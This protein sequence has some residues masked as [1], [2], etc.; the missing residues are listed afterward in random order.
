MH[1]LSYQIDGLGDPSHAARLSRRLADEHGLRSRAD[2]AGQW[3]DV[4]VPDGGDVQAPDQAARA[5]ATYYGLVLTG[6]GER[7]A[8]RAVLELR[9]RRLF[10]GATGVV[11]SVLILHFALQP[12]PW[13]GWELGVGIIALVAPG[14]PIL[15]RAIVAL[16]ALRMSP[17]LWTCFVVMVALVGTLIGMWRGTD[18]TVAHVP[19][20]AVWAMCLQR[21]LITRRLA[22]LDGGGRHA[23]PTSRLFGL[24]ALIVV[25]IAA[26]VSLE[27]G[28]AVAL[29]LP[30]MIGLFSVNRAL[31]GPAAAVPALA[32]A[33]LLVA[34]PRITGVTVPG[35]QAEAAI[36]FQCAYVCMLSPLLGREAD[37]ESA[38][39]T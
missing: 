2:P 9:W 31:P 10:A 25:A 35:A 6:P 29:C 26:L 14:R 1:V 4:D 22:R 30:P 7:R 5:A 15:Y 38:G 28:L 37:Q 23:L 13:S 27:S 18:A 8:L 20:L 34:L 19:A 3:L 12:R 36:V 21:W 32:F 17:D 16:R 39:T 11:V 24:L 33:P